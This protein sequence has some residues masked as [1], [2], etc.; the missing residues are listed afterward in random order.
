M[1]RKRNKNG[2][3]YSLGING[4]LIRAN[5]L[6]DDRFTLEMRL[7]AVNHEIQNLLKPLVLRIFEN[8]KKIS[9]EGLSLDDVSRMIRDQVSRRFRSSDVGAAIRALTEEMKIAYIGSTNKYEH[10]RN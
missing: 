8:H 10:I 9:D 2:D 7:D 4:I 6:L 3:D 5:E 1:P